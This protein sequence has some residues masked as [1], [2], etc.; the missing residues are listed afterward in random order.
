MRRRGWFS[1]NATG[2]GKCNHH[3]LIVLGKSTYQGGAWSGAAGRT[4]P[5]GIFMERDYMALPQFTAEGVLPNGIHRCN[6]NEFLDRFCSSE[7]RKKYHKPVSDILDFSKERGAQNLIIGGSFITTAEAP[8]DFDCLMVFTRDINIPHFV[9]KA[10]LSGLR[11][12][13]LYASAENPALVDAFISLFRENRTGREC[14]IVEILLYGSSQEWIT[15]HPPDGEILEIVKRAYN[16]HV[17]ID[18]NE[19]EGVLVTVHGIL[20][21]GQWNMALA[22]VV[23]NQGWVFAPYVYDDN[24]PT[25]LV[26]EKGRQKAVDGFR[27]WIF[28][29]KSK[30][31]YPISVLAHSFGTFIIGDYIQGFSAGGATPVVFNSIILTGSILPRDYDWESVRG[32]CVGSVYNEIAPKDTWVA[33]LGNNIVKALV[34]DCFG[35]SGT[36]GFTC[37]CRILTQR[38]SPIFGHNNVILPDVVETRWMPYLRMHRNS[39]W[40]EYMRM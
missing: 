17:I 21:S 15:R 30:Y 16:N 23:S 28:D 9:D 24:S 25:V 36:E 31:P 10:V 7:L 4:S 19:P 18:S 6:G 12:D 5:E 33:L 22:P 35:P 40:N 34:G 26:K 32:K 37:K 38:K 8:G 3:G 2:G 1:L 27:R 13:V 20:S 11:L 39:L 29:L 14:G